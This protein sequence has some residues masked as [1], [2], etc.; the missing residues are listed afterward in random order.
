MDVGAVCIKVN[1]VLETCDSCTSIFVI[2]Y[3]AFKPMGALEREEYSFFCRESS[4]SSAE[5]SPFLSIFRQTK[6][7]SSIDTRAC[8]SFSLL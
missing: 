6:R 2:L 5:V 3:L 7:F 1:H 8:T 4:I